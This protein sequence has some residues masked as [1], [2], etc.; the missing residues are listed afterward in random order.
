MQASIEK[1]MEAQEK[2]EGEMEHIRSLEPKVR[3]QD[4]G[5]RTQC[6]GCRFRTQ[7]LG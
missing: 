4:A 3:V 5:F 6:L 1:E 7:C 2:L